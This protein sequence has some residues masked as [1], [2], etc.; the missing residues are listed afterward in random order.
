MTVPSESELEFLSVVM[1]L[2]A[3]GI[4]ARYVIKKSKFLLLNSRYCGGR[5]FG[6]RNAQMQ[7]AI[8]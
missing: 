4:S 1:R 5:K 6:V 3:D 2:D 7:S 8:R